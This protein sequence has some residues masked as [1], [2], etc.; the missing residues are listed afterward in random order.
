[1]EIADASAAFTPTGNHFENPVW[2]TTVFL[3]LLL[4]SFT[5]SPSPVADSTC[6][7]LLVSLSLCSGCPESNS[8]L[9]SLKD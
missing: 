1:M 4:R 5:P 9:F 8:S 2:L 7:F 6:R 3:P